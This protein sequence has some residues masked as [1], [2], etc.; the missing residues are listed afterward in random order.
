VV[1]SKLIHLMGFVQLFNCNLEKTS[2]RNLTKHNVVDDVGL[3][4][5]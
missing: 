3:E 2:N 4:I 5:E 1:L